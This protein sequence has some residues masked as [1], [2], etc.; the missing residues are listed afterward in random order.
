MREPC[1]ALVLLALLIGLA[2]AGC[3]AT[4]QAEMCTICRFVDVRGEVW[5]RE[6]HVPVGTPLD[7]WEVVDWPRCS[8]QEVGR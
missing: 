1:V 3:A 8:Y 4:P 7:G 5:F 2:L 6:C